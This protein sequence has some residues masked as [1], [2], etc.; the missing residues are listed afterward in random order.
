MIRELMHVGKY[1]IVLAPSH[2]L[3]AW[4]VSLAAK[5]R[6]PGDL[7]FGAKLGRIV[8][9]PTEFEFPFVQGGS[10]AVEAW[11]KLAKDL[12]VCPTPIPETILALDEQECVE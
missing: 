2:P 12:N 8:D 1:T 7:P 5:I 10:T 3:V 9:Y 11:T 4:P 6:K